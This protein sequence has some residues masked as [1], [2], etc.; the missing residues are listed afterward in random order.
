M[1]AL[2]ITCDNCGAKYKLPES[3]TGAQAKC[4]KCGS[5]IDVQ[6]QRAAT[7]AAAAT[8]AAAAKPAAAAR[9]AIDRSKEAP[10]P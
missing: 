5:V 4:Q 3:F 10:K 1:T 8:P 7:G 6:K 9:P 2:S